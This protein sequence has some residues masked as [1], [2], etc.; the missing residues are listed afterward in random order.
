MNMPPERPTP[1]RRRTIKSAIELLDRELRLPH[2]RRRQC[3]QRIRGARQ[4]KREARRLIEQHRKQLARGLVNGEVDLSDVQ[5]VLVK[6]IRRDLGI[7][8]PHTHTLR[9]MERIILKKGMTKQE[10]ERMAGTVLGMKQPQWVREFLKFEWERSRIGTLSWHTCST[11]YYGWDE[12]ADGRD[13][14]RCAGHPRELSAILPKLPPKRL[15]EPS[16]DNPSPGYNPNDPALESLL[17]I[18]DFLR[19]DYKSKRRAAE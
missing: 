19:R 2:A 1:R 7:C 15:T 13:C 12:T 4:P 11:C 3:F 14:P 5:E 17:E 16:P 10:F 6:L 18:P 8:S 9:R